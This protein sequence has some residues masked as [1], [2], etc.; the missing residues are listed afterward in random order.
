MVWYSSVILLQSPGDKDRKWKN[1]RIEYSSKQVKDQR[2]HWHRGIAHRRVQSTEKEYTVTI[3]TYAIT[4]PHILTHIDTKRRQP[5]SISWPDTRYQ[6]ITQDAVLFPL[7]FG[8]SRNST[9]TQDAK[10]SGGCLLPRGSLLLLPSIP[11]IRHFKTRLR[12]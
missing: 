4:Y 2:Q 6:K 11:F 10:G 12:K 7:L 8:S 1:G 3:H 5:G 9:H